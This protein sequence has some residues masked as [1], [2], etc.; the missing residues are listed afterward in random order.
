MFAKE[1]RLVVLGCS[2]T[3][4]DVAGELPAIS[5]Y[6]GPFY[7]VLRAYLREFRWPESLSIAVLSAKYG[8]IGCVSQIENYD[9]RM[10]SKRACEIATGATRTF[11]QWIRG[12]GKVDLV[13]GKDYL[14]A[15]S[16]DQVQAKP[17]RTRAEVVEGGI[18]LKQSRFRELLREAGMTQ[19]PERPVL[20]PRE[21]PLYFLPDWDDFID[22]DFDYVR[23]KFSAEK[24]GDRHEQH[25]IALMQ[26]KRMCDGVLVSLAQHLGSKG[27]LRRIQPTDPAS[28]APT[29]VRRHFGL[30]DDQWAFG[31]CGAFSYVSESEPTV[32]VEQAVAMYDLYEFD[33]GASVDHIPVAQMPTAK[34]FEPVSLK[35][36]RRRLKLTADN[37]ERFLQVHRQ[38]S[39]RFLPVG[40]VQGL[41]PADYAT[42]VAKYVEMGY[43]HLAIGGLVPRS[44][45]DIQ[46][47]VQVIDGKLR[48][49]SGAKRPW[50]HLLGIFRPALQPLFRELR[51]GS[52]DSASYFRKAWLRSDQN[53]LGVDGNWY[54]AIRVPPMHDPRTRKRLVE[55]DQSEAMLKRL[56]KAALTQLRAFADGSGTVDK[57]LNAVTKYDQLLS[58][59]D[60]VEGKLVDAYRATLEAR[61]WEKCDCPR[62]QRLGIDVLI[63]RGKNRNKSR[64]AHNTLMLYQRVTGKATASRMDHNH[65]ID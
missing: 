49:M 36:R 64:G 56:E 20:R 23:D 33:L 25:T 62:C 2:E 12:H 59:A 52:F 8:L 22:P 51:I 28:L 37:A 53:Y 43:Q 54:A 21:T 45:A 24:R 26:P 46:A 58:R 38:R 15:L 41:E 19:H 11:Q 29:S 18:G 7:R 48:K 61:P 44:D 40:V 3:K 27:L 14:R 35:E 17:G 55:N 47:I 16:L 6:D 31:D 5:L 65:R 50:I 34:G 4:I 63:F 13:L 60:S 1:K 42:Y 32:T 9:Q 30:A 39:A 57:A 10:T